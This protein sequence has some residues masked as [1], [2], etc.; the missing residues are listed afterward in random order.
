MK[1]E[2]LHKQ[3]PK[4]SAKHCPDRK[5]KKWMAA[6]RAARSL[7]GLKEVGY[8]KNFP[9]QDFYYIFG[10]VGARSTGRSTGQ[11]NKKGRCSEAAFLQ[12]C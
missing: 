10:N 6:S 8:R 11:M 12:R 4:S 1:P 2:C 3:E 7:S 9:E 5:N